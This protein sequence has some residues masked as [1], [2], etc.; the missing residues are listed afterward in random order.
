MIVILL[1]F[2]RLF[3]KK[4]EIVPIE[5]VKCTQS[6]SD[7]KPI[8]LLWNIGKILERA[9]MY[10]YSK[11]VLHTKGS[12]QFAYQK[13]K[14]TCDAILSAVDMWTTSLDQKGV[15]SVPVAFLDM[16]KAFDRM[17]KPT[18]LKILIDRCVSS[19]LARIFFIHFLE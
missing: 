10:F 19:D 14:S 1:A 18:L 4:S 5:K 6:P 7:F 12:D 13:G 8:S 17:D 3:G 9:I 15:H 11:S 2:F 16:S